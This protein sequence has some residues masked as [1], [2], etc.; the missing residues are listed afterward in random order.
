MNSEITFISTENWRW[1]SLVL[2]LFAGIFCGLME[3]RKGRKRKV[4][5]SLLLFFALLSLLMAAWR[6]AYRHQL[7][8]TESMLLLPNAPRKVL[9]SLRGKYPEGEIFAFQ[10]ETAVPAKW[11]PHISYLSNE[12]PAGSSLFILGE[13][14]EEQKANFLENFELHYFSGLP[15]SGLRELAFQR[16]LSW[17]EPF[18][19]SGS[20]HIGGDTLNVILALEGKKLDSAL[21]FPSRTSFRLEY[22]PATAGAHDFFLQVNK[23]KGEPVDNIPLRIEVEE[24]EKLSVALLTSFPSFETRY[25]K[26]WLA[27]QGH[28]VYYQAEMAP[29]R[30]QREQLNLPEKRFSGLNK[31]LLQEVDILIMDQNF[32]DNLKTATKQIVGEQLREQGLGILLLTGS[33]NSGKQMQNLGLPAL[34]S[35]GRE[36]ETPLKLKGEGEYLPPLSFNPLHGRN[37]YSLS[38]NVSGESAILATPEGLGVAMVS[39]LGNTY[40]LLLEGKDAAYDRLWNHVLQQLLKPRPPSVLE[41][42]FPAFEG[43][44]HHLELW[45]GAGEVP[46]LELLSPDGKRQLLPLVQDPYVPERWH[47]YHWPIEQGLYRLKWGGKDSLQF[48]V[49]PASGLSSW[50]QNKSTQ[51]IRSYLERKE[52]ADGQLIKQ[53][54]LHSQLKPLPLLP[55]YL[56]FLLSMGILWLE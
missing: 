37:W 50:R 27:H 44:R 16:S 29:G 42:D 6:P 46:A 3:Y 31:E 40:T 55:F 2:V 51:Q 21:L 17:S 38:E 8:P 18:Q 34:S 12:L 56:L 22:L 53:S 20:V 15:A 33:K 7:P 48:N 9:D 45:S 13:G 32:Q 36:K 19:V 52:P 43:K 24:E 26:N 39:S 11:L 25:L 28:S 54:V 47:G 10:E 41:A 30:W 35:V 4:W 23:K 14:L 1:L 49:L 5:R